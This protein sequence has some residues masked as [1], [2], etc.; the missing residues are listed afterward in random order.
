MDDDGVDQA[1]R[2][3]V[4]HVLGSEA[5][6]GQVVRVVGGAQV[7][8][9]V[10]AG[11]L[12]GGG[13]IGV[14]HDHLLDGQER[15]RT[16]RLAGDRGVLGRHEVSVGARGPL[17]GER[18][19]A[20]PERGEHHLRRRITPRSEE[21]GL[22]HRVEVLDHPRVG[23][24]VV[25][26]AHPRHQVLVTDAETE[27]EPS[28]ERLVQGVHGG[29]GRQRITAVPV[30]D[31]GRDLDPRRR[32]HE[33]RGVHEGLPEHG[34][35]DPD[36]SVAQLVELGGRLARHRGGHHVESTGPDAVGADVDVWVLHVVSVARDRSGPRRRSGHG[37]M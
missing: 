29:V 4:G 15:L 3:A 35:G 22:G 6:P 20:R 12:P 14:Q 19:H 7:H 13:R 28:R 23:P 11:R 17:G 24:G 5:E 31:A 26:L 32:G 36:R 27:Q 37:L 33:Q 30:D 8:R 25:V 16:H 2:A 1:V 9:H 18:E 34:L 10:L 21:A